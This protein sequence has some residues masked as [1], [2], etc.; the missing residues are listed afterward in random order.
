MY[1]IK[2]F[3][4]NNIEVVELDGEILFNPYDVG[5]CLGL[6]DSAIR[7]A[8]GK[9]SKKQVRKLTNSI[10]KEI[11]FRKIHNTGENFITESGVYKLAFKSHKENA[12]RFQDWIADDVVPTIRKTGT[13]HMIQNNMDKVKALEIKEMNAR[14]RMS[15]QFLKL[16]EVETSMSK[17][18]KSILVA[19][20]AEV[21]AGE[22]L[23]PLPKSEQ[24]MYTATEIGE[25]FG[26]SK[27]KVG[28]IA[29]K[30]GLKTEEYGEWYKDKSPHSSKEVDSFRYND[31]AVERF[32]ELLKK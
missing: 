7:M 6:S 15:N 3:E 4:G 19:K 18:Y 25:M 32:R 24:K 21:L 28:S 26:I 23:L 8:I 31:K 11:D 1:E 5:V 2:I 14:V 20:A 27:Q 9:M 13:Y 22:E 12:E 10:V 17:D 30:N 29:N 16:A